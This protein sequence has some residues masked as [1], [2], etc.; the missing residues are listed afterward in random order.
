MKPSDHVAEPD[1]VPSFNHV[2][3]AQVTRQIVIGRSVLAKPDSNPTHRPIL[4]AHRPVCASPNLALR[5]TGRAMEDRALSTEQRPPK[6]ARPSARRE[7]QSSARSEFL[8]ASRRPLRRLGS[9][10]QTEHTASHRN[11]RLGLVH[12]NAF[13]NCWLLD[14]HHHRTVTRTP[15][16]RA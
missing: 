12:R 3:A 4:E 10:R 13:H 6:C 5:S 2:R 16:S 15:Q 1:G 14:L 9:S 11:S 7:N 8:W